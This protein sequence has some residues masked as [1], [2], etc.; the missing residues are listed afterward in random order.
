M[1]NLFV[2]VLGIIV[3]FSILAFRRAYEVCAFLISHVIR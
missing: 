2:G 1:G 3:G